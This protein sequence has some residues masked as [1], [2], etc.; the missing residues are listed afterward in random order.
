MRKTT[1]IPR[2][3]DGVMGRQTVLQIACDRCK[4]VEH[5]P[6]SEAKDPPKKGDKSQYMFRGTYK[7]EYAEFDDLCTGCEASIDRYWGGITKHLQ[8][9]SPV[10][11]KGKR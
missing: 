9:V 6:L 11:R 2:I 10:R 5:K 1:W 8:K 3:E 7:G 4:R